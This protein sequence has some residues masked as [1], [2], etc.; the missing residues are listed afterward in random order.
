VT[1]RAKAAACAAPFER[2]RLNTIEL[3]GKDGGPIFLEQIALVAVSQLEERRMEKGSSTPSSQP[4][5]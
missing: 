4:T 5:D 1:L 2:A 3:T